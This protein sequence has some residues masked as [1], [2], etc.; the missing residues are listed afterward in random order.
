M[1]KQT[2]E[3]KII[4]VAIESEAIVS[5]TKPG[6]SYFFPVPLRCVVFCFVMDRR[7]RTFWLANELM[8]IIE[9]YVICYINTIKR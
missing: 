7:E 3:K 8:S 6:G 5:K 4:T 1:S 2:I 9:L